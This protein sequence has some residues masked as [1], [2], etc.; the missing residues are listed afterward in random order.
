MVLTSGAKLGRYK[1]LSPLGVGGMGEVYRATDTQLGRDV[2][3]KV[4]PAEMVCNSERL[5]RFQR[6][7]RTVAS[8]NHPHIVTLYSVEEADGIP[9][10]TMEYVPGESLDRRIPPGGLPVSQMIEIARA[11]AE[12]LVAAHEKGII[13]RDLKPANIMVTGEGRVKVL[14]FGLA[15]ET[16]STKPDDATVDQTQVGSIV[17]TPAYM[18]PEQLLGRDVDARTDIF[19]LGLVLHEMATGRRAFQASTSAELVSAVLRDTPPVVTDVRPELPAELARLIRRCVEKDPPHRWQT[20][21]DVSNELRDLEQSGRR[22]SAPAR[23]K[24]GPSV[25]VMPFQNLSPDP[26]GEYFSDGLAEEILNALSQVEGLTVAARASSFYFKGK[27]MEMS[28]IASRLR[29]ANVL[30]GSVRRS[31]NRVRVT[32]QLVDLRNGFQL[33]SERYD[34]QM[35]DIFAI[36]DE[37]ARGIAERFKVT[38]GTSARRSTTNVEAYELYLKGRHLWHQRSP[39][40]LRAAIK[41]F[42]Q[43]I[44]L[45]PEYALAYSGLADSYGILQFYGWMP[46]DEGRMPARDAMMQA[47]RLAPELWEVQFSRGFYS[48]YFERTWHDSGPYFEKA[49]AINPRSSLTHAYYG[50][51]LLTSGR[52]EESVPYG[53]KACEFDP[54]SPVIHCMSTPVFL[55][56]GRYEEAERR[57]SHAL[58]MQPDYLFAL[59]VRS[60]A[61]SG[62]AR[63]EE[64]ITSM[65]RAI[66]LS[67][68]PI[69][70][71][72][73][74]L[75]YARAGRPED[76]TRLLREIEDRGSRGEYIPSFSKVAICVGLGD[77]VGIRT[78]LAEVIS[79]ATSP[80]PIRVI[81]GKYLEA[82]R[83]DPEIRRLHLDLFG[84]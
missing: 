61:L 34:R 81:C 67:R 16:G 56:T 54:L 76:A 37:I 47:V 62:M 36:Q 11:L 24:S 57:A 2:A 70:T 19:S 73:L 79:A 52:S 1:I 26:E 23:E 22:A 18:S 6:E 33:W 71:G 65:E 42:E 68:A 48:M 39:A 28:E 27:S 77:L 51:F 43:A 7:A 30:Q 44:Q 4:L 75:V 69:F 53:A 78:A 66:M 74:G 82:Y 64:A 8:L 49:L 32:V 25:A 3:L 59:W 41:S 84:W 31:G 15:K 63:H 83:S 12:A 5:A 55:N 40:T 50:L 46:P 35:E 60:L 72:V 80:V 13:H 20:A 17:G 9:F 58:E 14:D 45:D 38:F 10:L 21:R 29:V